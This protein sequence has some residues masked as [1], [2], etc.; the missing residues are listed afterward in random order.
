MCR[1]RCED[2]VHYGLGRRVHYP[3]DDLFQASTPKQVSRTVAGVENAVTEEHEQ[4]VGFRLK[5]ELVVLGFVKQ[6]ERQTGGFDH[7]ELAVVTIDR[8]RQAR[9]GHLQG[10]VGVIPNRVNQRYELC[11]DA[12]FTERE[13][14]RGEHVGWTGFNR[15]MRA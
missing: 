13:V 3:G 5:R 7:L 4:I 14:N 8:T 12:A 1:N 15:R 11:L 2:A 9:I 10:T 6:S